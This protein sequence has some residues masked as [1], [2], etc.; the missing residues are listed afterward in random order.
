MNDCRCLMV[1]EMQLQFFL[2]SCYVIISSMDIYRKS[3]L[4]TK[5]SFS[6]LLKRLFKVRPC[7]FQSTSLFFCQQ[8]Y[9]YN[10][11]F[12]KTVFQ[13]SSPH[14]WSGNSTPLMSFNSLA[15]SFEVN[16]LFPTKILTKFLFLFRVNF[17]F[18]PERNWQFDTPVVIHHF[19]TPC[20]PSRDV[21]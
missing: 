6:S 3:R 11:A 20:G 2:M 1:G 8:L 4:I 17:R 18:L 9:F 16:F 12:T 7:P 21:L 13:Q 5:Q 19:S 10:F 14:C 15:N